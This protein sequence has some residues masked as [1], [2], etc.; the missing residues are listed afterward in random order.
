MLRL[1][2]DLQAEP[3]EHSDSLTARFVDETSFVLS[4]AEERGISY[5]M[6]PVSFPNPREIDR[7][8]LDRDGYL[9]IP[10]ALDDVSVVRLRAA[11]E[12]APAQSDGTQHVPISEATPHRDAW[13]ALSEHPLIAAAA[14]HI[15]ARPFRVR[16]IHGRNPL[17]GYGQQGLH[18]DWPPRNKHDPWFA[19]TALWMLDDFTREN[20]ATRILPGSHHLIRPISKTYAQPLSRHPDE[21]VITGSAG[22]VLIFNGH[23]WHSGRRNESDGP[24]RAAQ[25]VIVADYSA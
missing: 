7:A 4:Q 13:R 15:L 22:S 20:G 10:R 14:G 1:L 21:L 23:L 11:F 5:D 9:V 3:A 25:M 8:T 12:H 18:A 6:D 24:R 19:V 2:L 17:P 16:D